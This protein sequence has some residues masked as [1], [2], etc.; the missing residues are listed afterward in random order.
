MVF[1]RDG[2][3]ELQTERERALGALIALLPTD[4]KS[5]ID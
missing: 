4:S 2:E 3:E 1:K 5:S